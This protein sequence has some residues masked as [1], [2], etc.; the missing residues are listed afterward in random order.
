MAGGG[1]RAEREAV[2]ASRIVVLTLLLLLLL[3]V[4]AVQ[5]EGCGVRAVTASNWTSVLQGEWMV[6][7]YAPWCPACQQIES[8]WENFAKS[9]KSLEINVGKVDVAEEP[10]LS[11]RFFV[12]T[13]PTIFHA[14]DGVFRRYL[15]S[16][17][18][19]EFQNYI[20][21]KKWESVEPV[22]G[23][24]SPSSITMYGMA[25]LFHL[26]GW[27]RQIHSYLT[28]TLGIPAWGSYVIFTLATLL[29][30]LFLGLILVLLADCISPAKPTYREVTPVPAVVNEDEEQDEPSDE[31]QEEPSDEEQEEPAEEKKTIS[32]VEDEE[33][34]ESDKTSGEDEGNGDSDKASDEDSAVEEGTETEEA[35]EDVPEQYPTEPKEENKV[36]QRQRQGPGNEL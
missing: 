31:E 5:A 33:N 6:K 26:S 1:E 11:G 2:S 27:I 21:E 16:R 36:R 25:G 14:K 15:G 18:S 22:A 9:S 4:G 28:D 8:D 13:L 24:K 20:L 10:G 30:G 3:G 7:F 12:T 32:D 19:E 23:W 35:G 29:I 34:G 17:T